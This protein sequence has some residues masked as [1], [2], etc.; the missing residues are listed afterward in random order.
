[1]FERKSFCISLFQQLFSWYIYIADPLAYCS[2][3]LILLKFTNF[4]DP[5]VYCNPP[6]IPDLEYILFSKTFAL[7]ESSLYLWTFVSDIV[8]ALKMELE[9]Y[10]DFCN[11]LYMIVHRFFMKFLSQTW[12]IKYNVSI[13]KR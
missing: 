1:M 5:P 4:V 10:C 12:M 2:P 11:C 3:P 9:H 8:F 13:F 6:A 7:K